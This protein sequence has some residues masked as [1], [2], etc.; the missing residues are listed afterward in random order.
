MNIDQRVITL[1]LQFNGQLKTFSS[2]LLISSQGKKCANP[3]QSEITVKIA[4]LTKA[5]T[6]YLLTQCSPFN[7]NRTPKVLVLNAGRQSVGVTQIFSGNIATCEPTEPP[8]IGLEFKCQ[9]GQYVKGNLIASQ[10]PAI[11]NL[12]TIATQV[13]ADCGLQCNFQA[14]DKQISNYQFTGGA[15]KQINNLQSAGGVD[16]WV[17]GDQLYV[18][19]NNVPL[20]GQA[21]IINSTS[22]MIGIPKFTEQGVKITYLL[23]PLTKLGGTIIVQSTVWPALSGNY[24][25]FE[26]GWDI[27]S[28]EDPF[29]WIANCKRLNSSGAVQATLGLK[30]R[31]GPRK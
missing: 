14:T 16:A 17:D 31:K 2:P 13:A 6:D 22:G 26:L 1:G 15:L 4:N 19:D 29:Y 8:D 30:H 23:S 9:A 3:L 27:S 21:Q 11:V 7:L 12:S 5:D 24:R 25:I 10:Q 28:R 18:T 20:K